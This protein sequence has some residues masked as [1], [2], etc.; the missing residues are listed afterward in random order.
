MHATNRA[1]LLAAS[2]LA[3]IFAAAAQGR[4]FADATPADEIELTDEII[5]QHR[6]RQEEILAQSRA[7]LG[8]AD[9]EKRDPTEQEGKELDDLQDEFDTLEKQI[10]RRAGVLSRERGANA[11]L[12]APQG[13]RTTASATSQAVDD[14]NP[15]TN[16]PRSS[17]MQPVAARSGTF[18]FRHQGEFFS[19]V[20]R[21]SLSRNQDVDARLLAASASSISTEGAGPD[22]GFAVPPDYR[23][24]IMERVTGQDSLLARCDVLDSSSNS[25]TLPSDMTSPWDSTGGIQAYWEGEAAAVTQSK[26]ALQNM[27]MRLHKL[28]ALVPVTEELLEDA[29]SLGSYVQR[30]APEKIDFKVSNAIVW[31]TGVGMPLGFMNAPCLSTVAIE[32]GPQTAD[33]IVAANISKMWAR[34][35]ASSRA[36]SVWLIHPD[37]EPQLDVLTV[38]Q[39]PV[40]LPP[41]GY[42][43]SPYGRLRGRPVIP[44]QVCKTVGD[45]GDFMLVDLKQYLAIKKAGG[46]KSATSIHL[47]FDQDITAFKFTFRMAGQPW[48]SGAQSALNGSFTQSP[49]VA[50]AAR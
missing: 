8:K 10:N 37:A 33:T 49:F 47:W 7:I 40:Y 39:Y 12:A 48:W 31:G 30:K 22:G 42:A 32:S 21:A 50:L 2:S 18:G 29:P 41:G 38:G 16:R 13:R 3:F 25:M 4:V 6:D 34:M 20:A 27:T 5:N 24:A 46:V 44:H 14:D 43:D 9:A 45:L 15:P 11:R 1:A 26:V 35:P 17:G 28:A 19:A 36:T 23:A